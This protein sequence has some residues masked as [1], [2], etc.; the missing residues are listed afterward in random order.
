MLK[1]STL[2]G[3]ADSGMHTHNEIL[4]IQWGIYRYR[5]RECTMVYCLKPAK[6]RSLNWFPG[7]LVA[8]QKVSPRAPPS[9]RNK[10]EEGRQD[11]RQV[12]VLRECSQRREERHE[13][14][15]RI[16]DTRVPFFL[17]PRH[18]K[19]AASRKGMRIAGWIHSYFFVVPQRDK[20]EGAGAATVCL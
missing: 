19:A 12:S 18:A 8:P 13:E 16:K 14:G 1:Q 2:L 20:R 7:T 15:S 3:S 9:R 11:S 10:T 4:S 5:C 6:L 17:F